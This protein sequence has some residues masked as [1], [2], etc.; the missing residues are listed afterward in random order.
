MAITRLRFFLLTRRQVTV[1]GTLIGIGRKTSDCQGNTKYFRCKFCNFTYMGS[2]SLELEQHFLSSHPNKVKTPPPTPLL[3]NHSMALQDTTAK[4]R[5][6]VLDA[7]ERV[8]VRAEDDALVGYSIPM[9]SWAGDLSR[10]SMHAYYCCKFCSWSCE[11][12]E[13]S[14][15]LLEHYEQR[16]R[17]SIGGAVCPNNSNPTGVD[18]GGRREVAERDPGASKN[19]KDPTSNPSSTSQG[20]RYDLND[21][22]CFIVTR[23]LML[24]DHVLLS[25][26]SRRSLSDPSNSD[27]EAVVTS[28]NCQLCDF[29]YSMAHSATVI[30]VA[31]LL[32]H[33]QHNHSIHRCC[34]QHCMYCPQGLCQ[35]QKHLGEVRSIKNIPLSPFSGR[36]RRAAVGRQGNKA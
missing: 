9:A 4:E 28:Y 19:R 36:K 10:G 18:R 1:G 11:W 5:S 7:S 12:S 31:P 24:F 30:V 35:P 6:P 17:M 34:I 8:A 14:A 33:Y 23:P 25:N 26:Q 13:G 3:A 15:K 16:H 27:A 2:N 32:L 29:R 20:N 22:S 21:P